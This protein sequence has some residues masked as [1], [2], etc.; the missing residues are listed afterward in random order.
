M[1]T[2]YNMWSAKPPIP[3]CAKS[4]GGTDESE[5]PEGW[6]GG[7]DVSLW[8]AFV[9]HRVMTRQEWKRCRRIV[10]LHGIPSQ[11]RQDGRQ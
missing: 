1:I 6:C 10:E 2:S 9:A 7:A 3:A 11:L 4:H 5:D 8:L